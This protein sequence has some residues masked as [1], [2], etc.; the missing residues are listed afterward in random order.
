MMNTIETES[1]TYILTPTP[2]VTLLQATPEWVVA[3]ATK[4]YTGHYSAEPLT[5]EEQEEFW[6]ELGA[7]KL[8][9]PM[10]MANTFWLIEDVT[11]AFTHQ[12]ARYRLGVSF[13][14][15]SQRFSRQVGKLARIAVPTN[16]ANSSSDLESFIEGCE[17]AMRTYHTL[18]DGGMATQ[19]ARAILPTHICTRLY[20]MISM[21]SL[22]HIYD[23][24]Q[25]CQ[26]Q[27]SGK[28]EKGEWRQ[29]VDQMKQQL[30]ANNFPHYAAALIAPWEDPRC[31]SCGFGAQFDRKCSFADKFAKNLENLYREGK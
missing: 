2:K 22:V 4:G 27:N 9:G 26:A 6:A 23:Q 20:A 11:R 7:T 28:G 10:E 29:L 25:C 30:E 3:Q 16:I 21:K 5:L 24:R 12:F 19:D 8:K 1:C 18:L 17:T 31:T 14:Q 13:V 15:E